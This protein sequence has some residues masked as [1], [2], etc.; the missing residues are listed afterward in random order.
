MIEIVKSTLVLYIQV[1]SS[2]LTSVECICET[3]FHYS[4]ACPAVI[5]RNVVG[6][7]F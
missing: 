2:G 7:E 6:F 4:P 3:L 1:L 5:F